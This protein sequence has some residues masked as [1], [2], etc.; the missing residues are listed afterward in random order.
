MKFYKVGLV[1]ITNESV[2]ADHESAL[3]RVEETEAKCRNA[4]NKEQIGSYTNFFAK[5]E[6]DF[7]KSKLLL[8]I[9]LNR[10][11]LPYPSAKLQLYTLAYTIMH[12]LRAIRNAIQVLEGFYWLAHALKHK[13]I[14]KVST[15]LRGVALEFGALVVNIANVFVALM[16]LVLRSIATLLIGDYMDNLTSTAVTPPQTVRLDA[17]VGAMQTTNPGTNHVSPTPEDELELIVPPSLLQKETKPLSLLYDAIIAK[18]TVQ[19]N[20]EE[21]E[22]EL[23]KF[24]MAL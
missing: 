15:L 9:Q 21:I 23:H 18:K 22:A 6:H 1:V 8:H 13:N 11:T 5:T 14:K 7:Q 17:S 20:N 4:R 2:A 19:A 3:R 12:G 24:Y 16:T 10:A